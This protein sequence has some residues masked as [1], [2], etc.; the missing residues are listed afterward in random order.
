MRFEI[1]L[2]TALSAFAAATPT[3]T[4]NPSFF[5]KPVTITFHGGPATYDLNM[6]ADGN[7]YAT[8]NG[9]NIN[10]ITSSSLDI[11]HECNFYTAAGPS[12]SFTSPDTEIEID[13]L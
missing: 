6:A 4:D 11:Y 9:L 2:I 7:N 3:G 13:H 8:N 10:L 1:P 12:L 5:Y